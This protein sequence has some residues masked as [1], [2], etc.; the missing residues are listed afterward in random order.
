MSLKHQHDLVGFKLRIFR[1][2]RITGR[3]E[4]GGGG[5]GCNE[6]LC[7]ISIRMVHAYPQQTPGLVEAY[8]EP[9]HL[10]FLGK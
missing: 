4:G 3:G 2:Y 8:L 10:N 6:T 7:T 5:Q 9:Y 1:S